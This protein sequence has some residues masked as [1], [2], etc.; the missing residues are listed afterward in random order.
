MKFNIKEW[1]DNHNTKTKIPIKELTA[2]SPAGAKYKLGSTPTFSTTQRN[3][4][5]NA[6]MAGY[7]GPKAE[8]RV[9][10]MSKQSDDVLWSILLSHLWKQTHGQGTLQGGMKFTK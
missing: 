1:L 10:R 5:Y 7:D 9:E 2:K 4:I 3:F 6:L 8:K